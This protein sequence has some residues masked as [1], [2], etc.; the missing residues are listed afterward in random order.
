[1]LIRFRYV[2]KFGKEMFY[3]DN[4]A[5][6]ACCNIAERAV[7]KK[8]KLK[9]L[10]SLGHKIDVINYEDIEGEKPNFE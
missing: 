2:K 9:H 1:M 4:D 8:D 7:F 6:V 3:P 5:A 10:I